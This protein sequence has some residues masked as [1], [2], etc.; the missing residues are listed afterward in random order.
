MTFKEQFSRDLETEGETSG[1][2]FM[3]EKLFA[4]SQFRD[5]LILSEYVSTKRKISREGRQNFKRGMKAYK[6]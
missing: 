1:G 3:R 5:A 4:N 6:Q 2:M